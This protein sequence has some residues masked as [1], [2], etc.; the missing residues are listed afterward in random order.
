MSDGLPVPHS[1]TCQSTEWKVFICMTPV[2]VQPAE[3]SIIL[4]GYR[5]LTPDSLTCLIKQTL[6]FSTRERIWIADTEHW[7]FHF[8]TPSVHPG[9][10]NRHQ[11]HKSVNLVGTSQRIIEACGGIFCQESRSAKVCSVTE[12]V[13][14]TCTDGANYTSSHTHSNAN[15]LQLLCTLTL[16]NTQTESSTNKH[17]RR[18][19]STMQHMPRSTV[20]HH[21]SPLSIIILLSVHLSLC[22]C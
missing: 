10:Q 8:K 14:W 13:M 15:L 17:T 7:S 19:T 5:Q 18:S 9:H 2:Y 6:E 12:R 21:E 11:W 4:A 1:G 22:L 16:T 3:P 20:T